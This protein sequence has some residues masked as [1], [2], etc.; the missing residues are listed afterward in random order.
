MA[1]A[2]VNEVEN[3]TQLIKIAGEVFKSEAQTQFN[4]NTLNALIQNVQQDPIFRFF[5]ILFY[6]DA[7]GRTVQPLQT[8]GRRYTMP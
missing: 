8:Y 2:E 3:A 6:S 7:L 4:I 5:I 1:E